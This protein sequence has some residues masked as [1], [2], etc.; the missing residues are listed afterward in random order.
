MKTSND[1][2][3]LLGMVILFCPFPLSLAWVFPTPQKEQDFSP[4]PRDE[5]GMS[6]DFL[7]PS[8]PASHRPRPTPPC[9]AKSY[10]CK[11]FIP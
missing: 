8:H 10:N 5:A 7:D 9:I 4:A 3:S 2:I 6:L 1:Q 11:F